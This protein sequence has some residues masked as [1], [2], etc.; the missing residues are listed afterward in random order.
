MDQGGGERAKKL[1]IIIKF[2]SGSY[3]FLVFIKA[4]SLRSAH[5]LDPELLVGN[6][7]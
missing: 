5:L 2:S 7:N 6:L 1:R 4:R 3:I